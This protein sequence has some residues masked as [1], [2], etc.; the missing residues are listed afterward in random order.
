LGERPSPSWQLASAPPA[1]SACHQRFRPHIAKCQRGEGIVRHIQRKE[2]E[3]DRDGG[4]KG[5]RE[6]EGGRETQVES[7]V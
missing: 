3:R 1:T 2:S 5:R 4:R 6:R 7:R